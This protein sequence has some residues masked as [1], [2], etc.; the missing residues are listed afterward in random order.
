MK[1]RF[2][3]A[4][5]AIAMLCASAMAQEKTA[6]DW[7]EEGRS[8]M[9][10]G[11]KSFDPAANAFNEATKLEPENIDAWLDFAQVLSYLNQKNES[12]E[13]FQKALDLTNET[14]KQNPNDA[15]A[16]QSRGIA[17]ASLGRDYEAT[18]SFEKSVEILNQSIDENP[19]DAEAWWL[20]ADNLDILGQSESALEAYDKVIE[21]NSS[22]AIGAWIRKSDVL[23]G[24]MG[25]YDES[26][27]AFDKA[28]DL[29]A[30]NSNTTTLSHAFFSEENGSSTILNTWTSGGRILR[31][32]FGR[33]NNSAQDYDLFLKVDSD[34]IKSFAS[35][36]GTITP[37]GK[38][39]GKYNDSLFSWGPNVEHYARPQP[40]WNTLG[41]QLKSGHALLYE[42]GA[43]E[44]AAQVY[45]RAIQIDS[46]SSEAWTGKGVALLAQ[47]KRGEALSVL[48]R[49]LELDPENADAWSYKGNA[50]S[51][52]DRIDESIKAY[53]RAIQLYDEE[54]RNSSLQAEAWDG[55][56]IALE[57]LGLAE[58]NLSRYEEALKA[59]DKAI[60]IDPA[61]C[62]SLV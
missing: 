34:Y 6:D 53:E 13:A 36:R 1:A 14:L 12:L 61:G 15:G 3:I 31:V 28:T 7:L 10:S 42:E 9:L 8:L 11:F 33:Y 52:M 49:A 55:K 54:I 44:V 26:V 18:R 25:R 46:N 20:K 32:S 45:D 59:Y 60:E 39:L 4:L 29:M 30:V 40:E 23:L 38:H 41:F 21:L 57:N 47:G 56:G 2:A 19:K 37:Q 16:W 17:L 22:K 27:R 62:R 51:S 48:D 58:N 43:V 5:L 24:Q 35:R 50:L